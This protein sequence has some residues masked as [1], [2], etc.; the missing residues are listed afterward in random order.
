M[1][2]NLSADALMRYERAMARGDVWSARAAIGLRRATLTSGMS[3]TMDGSRGAVH[4]GGILEAVALRVRAQDAAAKHKRQRLDDDIATH[5]A[6]REID[7]RRAVA[8]RL[9]FVPML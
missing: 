1:S 5:E 4:H 7:A 6:V 8:Q 3:S 9:T 2:P